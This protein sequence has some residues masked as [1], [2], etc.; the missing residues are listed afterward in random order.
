MQQWAAPYCERPFAATVSIPG[1]KSMTNR[2]LVLSGLASGRSTVDGWLRARDTALMID[3]LRALGSRITTDGTRLVVEPG[4]TTGPVAIDCGLA[5]TVMRF[6]PPVASLH[7]GDVTF[8]AD[9]QAAARPLTAMLDALRDIGADVTGDHLPFTV[10]GSGVLPGGSVT[11]DASASSQF[12]SGLLLSGAAMRDGLD[13]RHIGGPL[14]SM[15]HIAMTVAMLADVGVIVRA[16]PDRWVV[17]PGHQQGHEW[18]IEP[19]LSNAGPFLAAAAVTGSTVTVRQ[20]PHNTTQAGDYWRAFLQD[21]GAAVTL[22]GEGLRVVGPAAFDGFDV[23]LRAVGEL[24]PTIA[25]IAACARTPSTL[26]GIGHLRGHETDRLA[27]IAT[28]LSKVA[29]AVDARDDG[30]RIDPSDRVADSDA[31][32][33]T[34]ADHRMAT[35]GAILALRVRGL[36]IA[37]PATTA[38]TMPDFVGLWETMLG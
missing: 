28:E 30:L 9:P 18:V 10:H 35:M 38:K 25:A 19:D 29:V 22:N 14:P 34:Y 36:R 16:Q 3:G 32:I 21:R 4:R 8:T 11:I 17:E 24:T 1:S 12:V 23:D 20:W 2:A 31:L 6:L 15:P 26:T 27:A 5:G 7:R 13:L 33:E 37:D